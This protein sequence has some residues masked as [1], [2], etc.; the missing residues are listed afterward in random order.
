MSYLLIYSIAYRDGEGDTSIL[1]IDIWY[2]IP[3]R[4]REILVSYL[5]IYSI[6][7]RD[8]EGDTS[9][10][11]TDIIIIAYR[12]GEGDVGILSIDIW[13]SIPGREGRYQYPTH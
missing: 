13:Y 4:G 2:S 3:G 11:P 5:L 8:G 1:S 6:A 9:I 12:G 10:L 7:Y